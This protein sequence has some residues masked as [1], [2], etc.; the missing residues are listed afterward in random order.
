MPRNYSVDVAADTSLVTTAETVVATLTG[1]STA[2]AGEQ[3][4]LEGT[5]TLTLGT[6]TTAVVLRVR[7]DSLT[8]AVVDE[9][10]TEQISTAAGSAETHTIVAYD[11]SG[12]EI[13]GRTYVLTVSQTAASA[14]GSATHASLKAE[15][16]NL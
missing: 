14:N 5:V 2:R 12:V 15:V 13:A 6:S 9:L 4:R 8:G 1:V 11:S 10:A 3:I 7:A 16:G